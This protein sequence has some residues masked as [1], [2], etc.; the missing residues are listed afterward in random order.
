MTKTTKLKNLESA[1]A[2]FNKLLG[3]INFAQI[4]KSFRE[5]EDMTQAEFAR[6]I[7]VSRQFIHDI[8]KGKKLPPLSFAIKAS[9]VLGFEDYTFVSAHLTEQLKLNGIKGRVQVV[10][11]FQ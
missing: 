7:G 6:Q 1:R 3:Q 10:Y 9:K 5:C 4:L 11:S 8:E 2:S